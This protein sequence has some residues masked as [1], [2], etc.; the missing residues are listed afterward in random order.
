MFVVFYTIVGYY[1]NDTI[2]NVKYEVQ[3]SKPSPTET[4]K[5][6]MYSDSHM[7]AGASQETIAYASDRISSYDA[8]IA[9]L[10]GDIVDGSTS[11]DDLEFLT[12][13]LKNIKTKY[14]V[15]FI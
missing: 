1:H 15:Y 6:A 13:S 2:Q 12:S 7:G 14:G 11:L 4:M 5:I 8:D 9:I 3:S 10:D